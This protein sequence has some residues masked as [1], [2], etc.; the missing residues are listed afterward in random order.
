MDE[1]RDQG[2]RSNQQ[3]RRANTICLVRGTHLG[4]RRRGIDVEQG[5]E[6]GGDVVWDVA[7]CLVRV[8]QTGVQKRVFFCLPL[9]YVMLC[10]R[11]LP[12]CVPGG[13]P[14]GPKSKSSSLKSNCFRGACFAK[15]AALRRRAQKQEGG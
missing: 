7:P 6:L 9:V 4:G 3:G 5:V 15:G 14:S 10:R 1:P 8:C 13:G 12:I 11:E 2:R